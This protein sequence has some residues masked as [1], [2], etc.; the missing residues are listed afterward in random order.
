M[1]SLTRELVSLCVSV[2]PRSRKATVTKSHA[3]T[4]AVDLV[5][6]ALEAVKE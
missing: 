3:T 1:P 2:L 4:S 6:Q 5:D